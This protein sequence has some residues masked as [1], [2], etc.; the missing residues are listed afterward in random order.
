MR[1]STTR[2]QQMG[3]QAPESDHKPI[4]GHFGSLRLLCFGYLSFS[5]HIASCER[6]DR[7]QAMHLC[8]GSSPYYR[9]RPIMARPFVKGH[10]FCNT[11]PILGLRISEESSWSP[12]ADTA[13]N[14]LIPLR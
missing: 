2:T 14:F 4:A 10:N 3:K 6:E 1:V 11:R 7:M 12:D 8:T 9:A 5:S 13:K